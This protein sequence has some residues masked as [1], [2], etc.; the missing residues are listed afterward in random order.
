LIIGESVRRDYLS[1]YGYPHPTTP[2]LNTS[3]GLFIDGFVATA[4]NTP[5]SLSRSLVIPEKDR[6]PGNAA[7]NVISLANT[8][9]Y[10][11]FWISNQGRLGGTDTHVSRIAK[12][13]A[14][15][16]FLNFGGYGEAGDDLSIIPRM[17]K[18]LAIP[19]QK[20][21]LII[22][23]MMGSHPNP[24]KRLH[25]YSQHF[26]ILQSKNENCYLSTLHKL[27]YFIGQIVTRLKQHGESYSVLYF[28]DH[29]MIRRTD[30]EGRFKFAHDAQLEFKQALDVPLFILDSETVAH[31]MI[32]RNLSAFHLMDILAAWLGVDS[33]KTDAR[34]SLENFPEDSHIRAFNGRV[35]V[36]YDDLKDNL[37]VSK[38]P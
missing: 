18:I 33:D 21:R 36:N 13:S 29:A 32:K 23:H 24:C 16:A 8:A 11:T 38:S 9:G 3:P 12:K 30:S 31:R 1:V 19:S 15:V 17:E 2:F 6:M 34:Y 35:L 27:D 22:L 4:P 7:N 10:E 28:S 5:Q 26:D 20:D 37:A 25:D 14:H